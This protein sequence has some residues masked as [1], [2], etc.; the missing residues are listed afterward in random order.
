MSVAG[1]NIELHSR[2]FQ[3][4]EGAEPSQK[5]RVRFSGDYVAGLTQANGGN[6]A[7]AR[8]EPMLIGGLYPAHQ[9]DRILIKP[10]QVP[11]YLIDALVAVEDRD[12]FDHFGVSPKGIAR[13]MW[14]N[15]TSGRLVQGG[16]T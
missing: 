3:F 8:L 5:V 13:A 10:D 12:Y 2:G 1:N 14:I 6:L 11:A 15:A 9:E 16:S 4:Y 7:V